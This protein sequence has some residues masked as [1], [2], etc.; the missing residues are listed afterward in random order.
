MFLLVVFSSCV[1]DFEDGNLK[2]NKQIVVKEY[3]FD[4]ELRAK[5]ENSSFVKISSGLKVVKN[6]LNSASKGGEDELQIDSTRIKEI[7]KEGITTYTMLIKRQIEKKE[8]FENLVVQIDNLNVG[9]AYLI[10]YT[11]SKPITYEEIHDSYTF[12]GWAE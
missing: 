1:K 3:P 10:K 4:V 6:L 5:K 7:T 12:E 8:Y 2:N 9:K 11:P